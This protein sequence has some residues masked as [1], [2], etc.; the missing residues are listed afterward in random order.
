MHIT[1]VTG[2]C[3]V[4]VWEDL[5][6]SMLQRDRQLLI[7]VDLHQQLHSADDTLFFP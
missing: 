3:D 1:S 6:L 2:R 4:V 7:Q 5:D